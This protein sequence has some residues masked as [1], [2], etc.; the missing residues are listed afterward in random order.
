MFDWLLVQSSTSRSERTLEVTFEGTFE[1]SFDVR[2][3]EGILSF[4]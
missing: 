2:R 3:M 1:F 4:F